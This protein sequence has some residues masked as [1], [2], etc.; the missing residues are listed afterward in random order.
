LVFCCTL[1]CVIV[2]L[3]P[4]GG[5][6]DSAP[7][8]PQLQDIRHAFL[9]AGQV[10]ASPA[11]TSNATGTAKVAL[12]AASQLV[13]AVTILS[14]PATPL[15]AVDIHD[16][17]IG[18]DSPVIVASLTETSPGV[19]T[20]QA[21]TALTAGQRER[22]TAAGF[23][24]NVRTAANQAGEIRGQ[25]MSFADNI[26]PI[27][28]NNCIACHITN[29]QAGFTGLFLRPADSYR[30]L[31]NTPAVQSYGVRVLPFDRDNSVLYQRTAG[32]GFAA[33]VGERM[34][35]AGPPLPQRELDLIKT[36]I[37]M[38]AMDDNG[39]AQSPQTLPPRQFIR[40]AFLKSAQIVTTGTISSAITGSATFVL[41]TAART[42]TGTLTISGTP[43]TAITAAHIHDG[44]IG[45]NGGVVAPL[46]TTDSV[47]FT[48]ASTAL[49]PLQ[50][51]TLIAGG[52]YVNVRTVANPDGEIRGQLMSYNDNV[53]PVF[54]LSCV[55]CHDVG[56]P[57]AFTGLHLGRLDSYGRLVNQLATQQ[58]S[59]E[60][61][62]TLV[63]PFDSTNSVLFRR[64]TGAAPYLGPR[65]MPPSGAPVSTNDENLIKTWI[66]MGTLN[67]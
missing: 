34:P 28:D 21:H 13:G 67:N 11:I 16:G 31:V 20:I 54:N 41:D 15:S 33:V 42:V 36:W 48:A 30:T 58:L 38:G 39:V 52:F 17:E 1:F 24:V 60:P 40:E 25:L 8:P 35:F 57:A 43:A 9:N 51:S 7:P 19:W 6:D 26:Q 29:G 45:T 55:F 37:M 32:V 49:T 3:S 23:Y 18:V 65:R 53:Q 59:T 47:I 63:I 64:V 5:K 44:F 27:F 50:M 4:C 2:F 14:A 46:T 66:D 62:A 12:D 56:G 10:F 22:F 61:T